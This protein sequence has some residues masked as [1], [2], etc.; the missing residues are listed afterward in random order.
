M[1][2]TIVFIN[3]IIKICSFLLLYDS[4]LP[5][6]TGH[7]VKSISYNTVI[8]IYFLYITALTSSCG[9]R[10]ANPGERQIYKEPA[11][12]ILM[13]IKHRDNVSQEIHQYK[14]WCHTGFWKDI[15][16]G[17]RKKKLR[18]LYPEK[19]NQNHWQIWP[20]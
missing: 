10:R 20:T 14:S 15:T 2:E 16:K 18:H 11:A 13:P 12:P 7:A 4:R 17:N 6:Q 9:L 1:T 3:V 19:S 8:E 5:P